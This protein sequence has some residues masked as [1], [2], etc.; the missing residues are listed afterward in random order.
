MFME[1]IQSMEAVCRLVILRS[2]SRSRLD[3]DLD[4]ALGLISPQNANKFNVES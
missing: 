2:R 1:F 4:L 3:L